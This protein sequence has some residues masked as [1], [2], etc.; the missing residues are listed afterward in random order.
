[1]KECIL[2]NFPTNIGDT[3]MGLPALDRLRTNYPDSEI[4]AIASPI[5]KD[6]LEHNNFINKVI[7][8]DKRWPVKQK[9]QFSFSLKN[10]YSII[11]D[12]KNSLFPLFSGGRRTPF[13]RA[14]PSTMH[15]KDFYVSL[16][17]KIAPKKANLHSD[18]FLGD[19][20]KAKWRDLKIPAALFIGCA[21]NALQKRY[22]Y[23]YLKETVS[24]LAHDFKLVILG[25]VNDRDFYKDMLFLDNVID[26]VGKTKL[27]ELPYILASYAQGLLCVDSSIMHIASY[28]NV[29]TVALFGQNSPIKYGPWSDKFSVLT[30]NLLCVPCAKPHCTFNHKCMEIEP[31]RVVEAVKN[32]IKR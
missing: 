9:I 27:Y 10:K 23:N 20:E 12:L 2:I 4:T 21:S 30:N 14:Y 5:T 11:V 22:P 16:V 1:M 3:V 31:K 13:Y 25:Q 24:Q 19:T 7:I 6:F 15:T 29:P 26:L 28:V 17:K 32:F 18:F 8:F